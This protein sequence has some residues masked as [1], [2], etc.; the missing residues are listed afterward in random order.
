MSA[1][2][3]FINRVQNPHHFDAVLGRTQAF[4]AVLDA[5]DEMKNFLAEHIAEIHLRF[6]F[7]QDAF[8]SRLF[9][10]G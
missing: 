1:S 5:V 2:R 9:V 3:R 10:R 6:R 8:G 7:Q 4:R